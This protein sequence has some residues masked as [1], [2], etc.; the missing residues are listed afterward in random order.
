MVSLRPLRQEEAVTAE[1]LPT[2]R[3]HPDPIATGSVEKS[4]TPCV[5]CGKARG[6]VYAGPVYA[7]EEYEKEICPWCIA[8]GSAHAR[9]DCE[10]V[11]R[12]GVGGHGTWCAVPDAV[13]DEVAYR[14]PGFTG[15]Q[16]ERWFTHCGDAASFLGRMGHRDVVSLGP[17]AVEAIRVDL[18]WDE[19]RQWQKY[20]RSLDRDD[21]PTAYLFRCLRCGALGGYSDFT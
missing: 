21:Q 17:A 7:V 13:A 18:G 12:D 11:G 6:Y 3:Y 5:A 14:T 9:L 4:K 1:P 19:G 8:D 15:W 16:Q 20:L 10:F 2:F